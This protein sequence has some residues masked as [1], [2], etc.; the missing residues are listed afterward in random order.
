MASFGFG[1]ITS[2]GVGSS[3]DVAGIV[4]QLM[5]IERVP[6]EKLVAQQSSFDAKISALGSIKSSLSSL[7]TSLAGLTTGNS[8]LANKADSSDTTII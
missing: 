3:L 2:Q 8:I 5:Q 7:Q 6:L 4:R 1:T